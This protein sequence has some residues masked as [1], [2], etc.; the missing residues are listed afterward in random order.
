MS[1]TGW[2]IALHGGAGVMRREN[3]D[4]AREQAVRAGLA[5][6]LRCGVDILQEGGNSI[7]AVQASVQCLEDNPLF[8]A[9]Y[10]SVLTADGTFELEAAIMRGSDLGAGCVM[11]LSHIQNPIALARHILEHSEHIAFAGSGAERYAIKAG[12]ELIESSYFETELRR[13]QLN[14]KRGTG[15]VSLDHDGKKYGTVGAVARDGDGSLA[16]ATST[17]GLANKAPGRI[18]DSSMIGAGTYASDKSCAISATG[19]GEAFIRLT[20]ARSIA[21]QMEYGGESLIRAAKRMVH[22]ELP[23]IEGR[24]GIIGVG[25]TGEPVLIFNTPGM[26]RASQ[27]EDGPEYLGIYAD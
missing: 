13:A 14:A 20:V 5:E 16:A 27:S 4:A 9:G 2:A 22:D 11:G 17:G 21:A 6:A 7:N 24:G 18:S 10:G 19:R 15:E 3:M 12:F 25:L 23:Q 1:K 26:Y 8:N